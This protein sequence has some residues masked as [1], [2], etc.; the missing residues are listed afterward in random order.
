[1]RNLES[2]FVFRRAYDASA[3]KTGQ[4]TRCPCPSVFKK[5]GPP[6]RALRSAVSVFSS[7]ISR[8]ISLFGIMTPALFCSE[9]ESQ[10]G[11]RES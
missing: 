1:M 3:G 8:I 2:Q 11:D 7:A 5:G 9:Q 6:H 4:V 10:G